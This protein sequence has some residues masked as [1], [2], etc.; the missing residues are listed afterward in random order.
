M[1]PIILVTFISAF[2]VN[3]PDLGAPC[4]EGL[5][6]LKTQGLQIEDVEMTAEG[7]ILHTMMQ[8]Q[9]LFFRDHINAKVALVECQEVIEK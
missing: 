5:A 4:E 6:M 2:N 7:A 8:K 1:N 9:R 3:A